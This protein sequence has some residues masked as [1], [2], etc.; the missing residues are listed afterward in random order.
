[1]SSKPPYYVG[2]PKLGLYPIYKRFARYTEL[3]VYCDSEEKAR[4][5]AYKWNGEYFEQQKQLKTKQ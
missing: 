1:M 4:Q 3:V 5:I 2:T